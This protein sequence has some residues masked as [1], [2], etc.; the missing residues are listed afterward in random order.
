MNIYFAEKKS[1]FSINKFSFGLS[2]LSNGSHILRQVDVL[3]TKSY[4]R[5]IEKHVTSQLLGL[6]S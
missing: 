4:L 3:I 5:D 1:S 2:G 6:Q